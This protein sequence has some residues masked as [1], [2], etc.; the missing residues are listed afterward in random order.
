MSGLRIISFRTLV[1]FFAVFGWVGVVLDSAGMDRVL[2]LFIAFAAGAAVMLLIAFLMRAA[3]KLQSDGTIDIRSAL[4][5][6]GTVYLT[7]P[8]KRSGAG[9]VNVTV[10]GQYSEFNAVTDEET[11]LPTGSE[12]L[13]IGIS[14]KNTLVVR[15]K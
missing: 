7:V 5:Q 2:S 9:K 14:G 10:Q 3:M 12:A 6:S 8:P 4:G 11:P 1:S 13:V 15:R